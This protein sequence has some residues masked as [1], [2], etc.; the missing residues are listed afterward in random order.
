MNTIHELTT[1]AIRAIEAAQLNFDAVQS[2]P[3]E[4]EYDQDAHDRACADF[5]RGEEALFIL[6]QTPTTK[7]VVD[8]AMTAIESNT[9][10]EWEKAYMTMWDAR[11]E[12]KRIHNT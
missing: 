8:D 5:D 7:F 9:G 3:D 6:W 10:V 11:T 1:K 4:T 12:A 2:D